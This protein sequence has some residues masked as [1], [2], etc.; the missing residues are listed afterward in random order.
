MTTRR[1]MSPA[2]SAQRLTFLVLS[3]SA[4]R[5]IYKITGKTVIYN[6][7]LTR[8]QFGIVMNLSSRRN[9]I[10]AGALVACLPTLGFSQIISPDIGST[11]PWSQVHLLND[12][13]LKSTQLK[14]QVL[15]TYFW[16]SWCPFCAQQTPE[17]EKLSVKYQGKGLFVLGVSIDKDLSAA[18][19]HFQ[20]HRYSF[21]STWLDP[22]V[23][24]ELKKPSSVPVVT[25]YDKSGLLV[26]HE[27]GQMFAEDVQA[28]SRWI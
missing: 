8:N 22:Q 4:E 18:K 12:E 7:S 6:L 26:Q 3:D 25:V 1:Q 14:G 21:P 15:V 2:P 11:I 28:L 20:K 27:K 10:Q 16:A 17:I 5:R 13:V 24:S 23:K 19:A 9:L